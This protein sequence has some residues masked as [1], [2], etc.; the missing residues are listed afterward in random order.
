M[1][2]WFIS[3]TDEEEET[4]STAVRMLCFFF[5]SLVSDVEDL[6]ANEINANTRLP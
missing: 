4:K 5:C 2:S 6:V 1:L 3:E